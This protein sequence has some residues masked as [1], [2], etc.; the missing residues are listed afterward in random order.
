MKVCDNCGATVLD[1]VDIC[2]NCGGN[3]FTELLMS[4][5]IMSLM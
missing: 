3:E 2:P 4:V 5:M 1:K